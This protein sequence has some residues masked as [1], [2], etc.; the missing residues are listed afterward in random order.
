MSL[1]GTRAQLE[2][3]IQL[4]LLLLPLVTLPWAPIWFPFWFPLRILLWLPLR[5]LPTNCSKNLW[6]TTWRQTKDL[7]SLRRSAN[8]PLRLRYQR[9]IMVS[10]IW[11]A[12]TSVRNAKIISRLPGLPD[13]IGLLLQLLFFVK[14]LVCVGHSSNVATEVRN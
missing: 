6:K 13:S 3:L 8:K 11:T 12:I 5:L 1:P 2:V 4:V 14:T 7:D 10:P 9:Y